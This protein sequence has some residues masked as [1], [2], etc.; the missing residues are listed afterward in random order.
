MIYL[1]HYKNNFGDELAPYVIHKLSG[2]KIKYAKPFTFKNLFLDILRFVKKIVFERKFDTSL[3]AYFPFKKVIISIGSILEESTS[4]SIVWG[5]GLASRYINIK[6]GKFLAVRGPLS[7]QRLEELNYEIPQIVGDP[8]ILLPRVY[9]P[10]K[11]ELKGMIGIIPHKVDYLNVISQ[12]PEN[13]SNFYTIIGLDGCNVEEVVDKI[14]SCRYIFSSSLHGIIVAHAYSIPALRF[15]SNQLAGDDSKFIDYLS[16][17]GIP[18][19]EPLDLHRLDFKNCD[20]LIENFEIMKNSILP[21]VDITKMQNNLLS[22]A[23]FQID[24]R[25][26]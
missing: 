26:I 9:Q 1:Y 12:I 18:Y 23:P 6:G 3:L 15:K 20:I 24:N 13:E 14:F 5:A 19:Y 21:N 8:A 4:N 17:V 11:I 7:Q 10:K 2:Q 25:K 22:I 16:S